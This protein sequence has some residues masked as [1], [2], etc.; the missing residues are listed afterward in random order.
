MTVYLLESEVPQTAAEQFR[1]CGLALN[2]PKGVFSIQIH[3][4]DLEE[5]MLSQKLLVDFS[6]DTSTGKN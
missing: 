1:W 6:G 2:P 5:Y 4:L 3:P